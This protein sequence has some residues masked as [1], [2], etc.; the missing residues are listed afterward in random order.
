MSLEAGNVWVI[1][2]ALIYLS[3]Q[4]YLTLL[5]ERSPVKPVKGP[6]ISYV[7]LVP[8]RNEERTLPYF[9][10]SIEAQT[11]PLRVIWGNDN[12]EDITQQILEATIKKHKGWE[13]H[14]VSPNL[15][16][17]FPGKHAVL[18]ELERYIEGDIFLIA[19][20][21]MRFPPKWA[22]TLIS[23]LLSRSEIGGACGPSLPIE[24]SIWEAF[25]RIEWAS[26]LYLIAA[27]QKR[28]EVVTA[29]GNSMAVRTAA[30]ATIGGWKSLPPSLVEDYAFKQA[31]EEAGWRF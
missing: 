6:N 3:I 5:I 28:G 4:L 17:H 29:I 7:L 8:V 19:D 27:M 23:R 24:R 22:E 15:H 26:I 31:I 2:I 30:W 20:A 25:Q 18:V 21:D 1:G 12:S 13:I 11:V 9:I 14:H 10:S 16:Q